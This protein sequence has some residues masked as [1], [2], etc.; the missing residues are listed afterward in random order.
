[1]TIGAY[2][3]S[4]DPPTVAHLAVADAALDQLGLDRLDLV[5]SIDPLGKDAGG[6]VRV[7]DRIEVLVAVAATR[8]R[9]AVR[10]TGHRLITDIAAGYDVVVVGADKW[11]QVL[12]PRWYGGSAVERDRALADL[13]TVALAPRHVEPSISTPLVEAPDVAVVELDV[14]PSHRTVSATSVR[15]GRREWMADAAAA[16]DARTGAW[17]DPDRYARWL[18]E[19]R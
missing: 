17:S 19:I 13:G 14:H 16:F 8:P 11:A 15:S 6:Q 4:F 3:G 18:D 2:P 7:Q 1:M 12:D 5:I 10:T 9:L